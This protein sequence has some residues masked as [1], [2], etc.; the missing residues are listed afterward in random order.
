MCR[1]HFYYCSF[2]QQ[3]FDIPLWHDYSSMGWALCC[4]FFATTLKTMISKIACVLILDVCVVP[5]KRCAPTC[6]REE[7]A[8]KPVEL[9]H[10]VS[11]FF[12]CLVAGVFTLFV[13]I[14]RW[15]T[16]MPIVAKSSPKLCGLVLLLL[17]PLLLLY[18]ITNRCHLCML[19]SCPICLCLTSFSQTRLPLFIC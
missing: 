5:R 12:T 15:N 11:E 4:F 19:A 2:C 8:V 13:I 17:L 18:L 14:P 9:L 7:G 6:T 10:V 16:V 1:R 3:Y